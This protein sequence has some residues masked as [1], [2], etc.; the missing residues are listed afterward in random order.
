MAF[1]DHPKRQ[2][3]QERLRTTTAQSFSWALSM[4]AGRFLRLHAERLRRIRAEGGE[5]NQLGALPPSEVGGFTLLP[6][7]LLGEFGTTVKF[8]FSQG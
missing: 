3:A 4:R 5:I 7:R 6:S 1:P 8:E 2:L